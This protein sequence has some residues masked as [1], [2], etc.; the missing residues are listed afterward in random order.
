MTS[1]SNGVI[2][3]VIQWQSTNSRTYFL[4][5][6][7]DLSSQPPFSNLASNIAGQALT[8]TYTDTTGTNGGPFFYRVGVQ[9]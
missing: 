8:T 6:S 2:G 7:A 9:E 3:P 4:G 1:I 5:R